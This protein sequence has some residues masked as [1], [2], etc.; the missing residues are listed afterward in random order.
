MLGSTESV[1][2]Q[3]PEAEAEAEADDH[4]TRFHKS[5]Q[6]SNHLHTYYIHLIHFSNDYF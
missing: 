6:V 2:F 4:W 1:V 5:L 3:H